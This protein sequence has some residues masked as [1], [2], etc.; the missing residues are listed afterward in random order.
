MSATID[1]CLSNYLI[2]QNIIFFWSVESPA[3]LHGD[4]QSYVSLNMRYIPTR[5]WINVNIEI[6][7]WGI[8]NLTDVNRTPGSLSKIIPFTVS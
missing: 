8:F 7:E 1:F 4:P 3:R 2:H 6:M 5:S